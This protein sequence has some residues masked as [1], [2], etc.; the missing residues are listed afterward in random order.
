MVEGTP[1]LRAQA[2]NR[3]E[4]SNPFGSATHPFFLMCLSRVY[5][6]LLLHFMSLMR[7][8]VLLAFRSFMSDSVP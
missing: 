7:R 8:T 6:V 2:G 4:G 3:L 5:R 1:L